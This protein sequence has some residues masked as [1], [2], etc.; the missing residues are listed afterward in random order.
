MTTVLLAGSLG[1]GW[2]YTMRLLKASTP[3]PPPLEALVVPAAP[4]SPLQIHYQ[5]EVPGRG[6]I[7]P[8][9]AGGA[10]ADY[11]PV[12]V[13][14]ITNGGDHPL[15]QTIYAEIPG[16]STRAEQTLV[17]AARTTERLTIS[18]ELLP[19]AYDNQEIRRANLEVGVRDPAGGSGYSQ[20]RPVYLHSASDLFWG[21]RFSNAQFI[22]RWVTPHDAAVLRLVSEAR[23]Y[24]LN[25]RLPGYNQPQGRGNGLSRQVR[26]QT[27][28]VFE[29]LKHTGISY[30]SSIFAF[31]SFTGEAQRIRLPEETLTLSTANCIDVS[32]A[33][34][35]AIEN[36][37]MNPVIVIVPGHAFA[38]VRLGP[39]SQDKLYLD[40]TVLPRGTFEQAV[41]RAD[42][43]LKKTPTDQVLMIDIAAARALRIYPIPQPEKAANVAERMP[44]NPPLSRRP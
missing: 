38:G 19:R 30:V 24:A 40:L 28:D 6:E 5:L 35:S 31:G 13:L 8:A 29:A 33:F 16:W 42:A 43:W 11:W 23:R 18:P 2:W 37:G 7:F 10:A 1:A 32:V 25:G 4:A 39:D 20:R 27:R 14:A 21:K 44:V 9:L 15:V 3:A 36:L 22:A 41:A 17:V 26:R 12:A 34:A